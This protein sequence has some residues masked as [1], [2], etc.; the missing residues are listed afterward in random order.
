MCV[1]LYIHNKY[2]KYTHIQYIMY[3]Q[4]LFWMQ[5]ITISPVLFIYLF[6]DLF[7]FI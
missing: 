5:L 3:T 1:Y 6:I 4:T 2:T 7:Q